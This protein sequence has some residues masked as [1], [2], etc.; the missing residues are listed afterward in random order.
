MMPGMVS[1]PALGLSLSVVTRSELAAS[2]VWLLA[3]SDQHKD[4]RYYELLEETLLDKFVYK[5]FATS[6]HEGRICAVQPFFIVDQDLLQGIGPFKAVEVV[7]RI[8]PRF[9]RLRTLMVG[10]AAGEGHLA[11][12][13]GISSAEAA[14]ILSRD[15][16][17]HAR[18]L[19]ASMIVLKEFPAKYRHILRCF[20]HEGFARIPSMPLTRLKIEYTDF[21]G[22][23]NEALNSSTRRKLRK[24]F[25]ATENVSI[26]MSQVDDITPYIEEIYPLYL[27]V[28]NR[29]KMKFEK[30]TRDYFSQIGQRM[31]DKV[32]F[33]IWRKAGMIVAFSLCLIKDDSIY[34]EYVGF[35]YEVALKLHLY[36]YI[37]RDMITWAMSRN[38]KWFRSTA[39]NYD[40]KLHMRHELDP[41]D[42]YVR[43]TS[44]LNPVLKHLVVLLD[45]VRR[46]KTLQKFANYADLW[47]AKDTGQCRKSHRRLARKR[48]A[49]I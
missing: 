16:T 29:S 32:R 21:E 26:E 13:D 12:D 22:Y 28:Y 48:L 15:I 49:N 33:F 10:C 19:G 31:P 9:L 3:F 40:P 43:F 1:T 25:R 7:R 42:L 34:A 5:Y 6:D 8:W 36:H 23:F 44:R 46:D 20:F 4:R 41:V 14:Q 37:V 18:V 11:Y 39:L 35:D 17:K 27:Q 24:K 30:L 47:G 45:P 38:Y 2:R